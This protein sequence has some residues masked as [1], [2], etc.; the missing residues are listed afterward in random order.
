MEGLDYSRT[1]VLQKIKNKITEKDKLN[2]IKRLSLLLNHLPSSKWMDVVIPLT[3]QTIL[4]EV[5]NINYSKQLE[6]NVGVRHL[7]S[8]QSSVREVI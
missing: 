4:D 2:L 6:I 3:L 8:N 7:D 5:L 1:E